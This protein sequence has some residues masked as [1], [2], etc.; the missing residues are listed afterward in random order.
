MDKTEVS[1]ASLLTIA[2]TLLSLGTGYLKDGNI[3]AGIPCIIVGFGLVIAVLLLVERG[4]IQKLKK[5]EVL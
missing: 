1:A 3:E 4:V 2:V 5:G